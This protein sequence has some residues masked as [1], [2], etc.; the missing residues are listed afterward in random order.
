MLRLTLLL[1]AFAGAQCQ[2]DPNMVDN[3]TVIVHMF[4][5]K[6]KDIAR[7]CEQFLGPNG[8]GGVQTS[9]VN[10][11]VVSP[12]R[13][14]QERYQPISYVIQSRS[15]TEEQ[16]INMVRRC[17]GAGVR[18][19]VDVVLNHMASGVETIVGTAGNEADPV[20]REY[21]AVP[22]TSEDFHSECELQNY[23]DPF[24]VR[25]CNLDKLP[26]LNHEQ[27]NVQQKIAEFLNKLIDY[28]V[29]GFNV[30]SCKH[31]W[32]HDLEVIYGSLDT[33]NVE[34]GFKEGAKPFLYQDVVDMGDE[35]VSK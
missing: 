11:Y 14:W 3:R 20:N 35:G 12:K 31:M 7:E 1:V 33:L 15:G 16:F 23:Q 29:A 8:F 28:G 30:D 9:P 10:E 13:T 25:N 21:S 22:Y 5:W 4:E 17:N 32:P 34:H 24:E 6:F 2:H 26:D 18:V 19:Y 27:E